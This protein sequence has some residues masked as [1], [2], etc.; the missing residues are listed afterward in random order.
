MR[1]PDVKLLISLDSNL[2]F[3]G[4]AE[5]LAHSSEFDIG[6][7][8]VPLLHFSQVDYPGLDEHLIDS[9]RYSDRTIIR[10]KGL[11]HFD[12]SSLGMI[13]AMLPDLVKTTRPEQREGYETVCRYVLGFLDMHM[14]GRAGG[15]NGA[16]FSPGSR[17]LLTIRHAAPEAP[18][19]LYEE[20]LRLI[21]TKGIGA[22]RGVY[23]RERR[24]SP[25]DT[26]F[27]EGTI[28]RMGYELLYAC[29][30]TAEAI[31]VFRWNVAAHPASFNVYDSLGEAYLANG[32][33]DPAITN[34]R[35]SLELNPQNTNARNVLEKIDRVKN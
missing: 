33:R 16:D 32:E 15:G 21:Q 14:R 17:G 25:R 18:G 20:F 13:S 22:A 1:N 7:M 30:M 29:R 11:T 12:F 2:G 6:R 19:P 10:V 31:E 3:Q 9:L 28:N 4:A 23:D 27:A 35:K 34:Y 8:R 5:F 24:A 26:L